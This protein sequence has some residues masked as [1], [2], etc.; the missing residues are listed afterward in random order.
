MR[1]TDRD[2]PSSHKGM[3]ITTKDWELFLG[4]AHATLDQFKVPEREQTE[5]LALSK[6]RRPTSSKKATSTGA[7]I[8]PASANK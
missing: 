1:Y 2:M 7:G 4:H 3:E 5:V 8:D 6:A